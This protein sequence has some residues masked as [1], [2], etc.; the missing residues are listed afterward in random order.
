MNA[1]LRSCLIRCFV[2]GLVALCLPVAVQ[3]AQG[4]ISFSG[5]VVAP[6]C[7]I[8][9]APAPGSPIQASDA[10][11]RCGAS[12]ADAGSSYSR[13]DVMLGDAV[14]TGDPLL[15]YFSSYAPA[16]G[17]KAAKVVVRTYD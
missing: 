5:A 10:H 17:A 3:A 14:V 4:E 7:A 6:T 2:A 1:S 16:D 9:T 15:G 12:A 8:D 11:R 13:T